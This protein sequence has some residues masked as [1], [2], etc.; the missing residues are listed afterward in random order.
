MKKII[1]LITNIVRAA[2][3]IHDV[4][5]LVQLRPLLHGYI[6][7]SK[8]AMRPS[9]ILKICN[10]I[11][12]NDRKI[13]L[14]LGSGASTVFIAKIMPP[15]AIL[16]SVDHDKTWLKIVTGW[17]ENEGLRD[18]VIM[19]HAPLEPM[20]CG[21]HEHP[22]YRPADITE[23]LGTH[24]I[25]C[26]IVDGPPA[27]SSGAAAMARYPAVP[28]FKSHLSKNCSIYL[29]DVVRDGEKRIA[30]LWGEELK[31]SFKLHKDAGGYASAKIGEGYMD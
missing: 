17:L 18:R 12:I 27:G 9:A 24:L 7:L 28:A 22:W 20:S 19:I 29:D 11:K 21:N 26:L 10:D 3:M 30:E 25:D 8:M 13:I 4:S 15:D 23:A 2:R 31:I 16:Y 5:A 14:E 1:T 6:P